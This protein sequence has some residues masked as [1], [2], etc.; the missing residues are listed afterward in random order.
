MNIL[1]AEALSA[2]E[3]IKPFCVEGTEPLCIVTD[4]D[5][6]VDTLTGVIKTGDDGVVEM[7]KLKLN[8]NVITCF[9]VEKL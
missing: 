1:P 4:G 9:T 6:G 7:L 8:V 3:G 5:I 2:V